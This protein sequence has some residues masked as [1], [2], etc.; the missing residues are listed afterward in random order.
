MEYFTP[1]GDGVLLRLDE[2]EAGALR[3]LVADMRSLLAHDD[4]S[5][6]A[7]ER[8]Y[9][10]AYEDPEDERKYRDLV[11]AELRNEKARALDTMAANMTGD[12]RVEAELDAEQVQRWL[13]GLTDMRLTLGVR[14]G[15]TEDLGGEQ[16]D[17]DDPEAFSW[18]L[19][20]W[21][22]W[23]QEQLLEVIDPDHRRTYG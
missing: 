4:R 2:D 16:I 23:L 3:R 15:V 14:L 19:L 10:N 12:G 13:T 18:S 6:P 20:H 8:L 9:P 1:H 21:L 5:D 22:G 17:P 7:L 11:G